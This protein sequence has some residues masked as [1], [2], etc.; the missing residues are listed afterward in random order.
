MLC[1]ACS[2]IDLAK[3]LCSPAFGGAP[4]QTYKELQAAA[5]AGCELCLLITDQHNHSSGRVPKEDGLVL[6]CIWN[7]YE[8]QEED[9]RGSGVVTIFQRESRWVI[10]LGIFVEE[11]M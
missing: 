6:A 9:Y 1:A 7:W 11:G 5:S 2:S 4:L 3:A 8:G 10:S